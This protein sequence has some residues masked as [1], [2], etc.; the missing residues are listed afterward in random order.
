MERVQL[1]MEFLFRASP[2]ILY[3]FLTTPSCL[4]RW[5]CD[6][7]DITG[8]HYKFYWDGASEA[9]DL[10]DDI[11]EERLRFHFVDAEDDEYLEF[12]I[13]ESP[14]TGETILEV[15]DFCDADELDDQRRLWQTQIQQLQAATG[16]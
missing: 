11:E 3:Q 2:A 7:I 13:S 9:A 5:F 1:D 16:G 4:T 15:T 6:E 10:I 14:V 8:D 12:R